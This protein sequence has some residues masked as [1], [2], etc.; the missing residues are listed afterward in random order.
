MFGLGMSAGMASFGKGGMMSGM[1][2][3]YPILAVVLDIG[4]ILLGAL[5]EYGIASLFYKFPLSKSAFGAAMKRN[6]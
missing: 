1:I 6:S 5:A 2:H 4:L 3:I